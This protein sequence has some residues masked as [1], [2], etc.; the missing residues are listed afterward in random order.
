MP[1]QKRDVALAGI[2]SGGYRRYHSLARCGGKSTLKIRIGD[3]KF[4]VLI[5]TVNYRRMRAGSTI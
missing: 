4:P 1:N 2:A 3:Q 5:N